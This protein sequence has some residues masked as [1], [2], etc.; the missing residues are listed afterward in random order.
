MQ[1]EILQNNLL[2][3]ELPD[4]EPVPNQPIAGLP[5]DF[6]GLGQP[7]IGLDLNVAQDDE[8]EQNNLGLQAQQN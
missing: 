8:D 5:F 6:F 2:G 3:A 7:G 1:C 4:E